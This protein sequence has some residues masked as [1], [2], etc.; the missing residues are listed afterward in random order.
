MMPL[1]NAHALYE[2]SDFSGSRL[3]RLI[4][5][6]QRLVDINDV[7]L[8]LGILMYRSQRRQRNFPYQAFALARLANDHHAY[9]LIH[10]PGPSQ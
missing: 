7:S 5:L 4:L 10:R 3:V 6:R 1:V 9:V 8:A 2:V